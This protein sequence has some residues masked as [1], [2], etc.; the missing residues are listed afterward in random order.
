MESRSRADTHMMSSLIILLTA[1]VLN[2]F[3]SSK[4]QSQIPESIEINGR[5]GF[6]MT[7]DKG[8]TD[9]E[10]SLSSPSSITSASSCSLQIIAEDQFYN[11]YP[12]SFTL[13]K[14]EQGFVVPYFTIKSL[15]IDEDSRYHG[16]HISTIVLKIG[17]KKVFTE[18]WAKT[19]HQFQYTLI[20]PNL[21]TGQLIYHDITMGQ[22]LTIELVRSENPINVEI[23]IEPL[24]AKVSGLARK[25]MK[26][27]DDG[28]THQLDSSQSEYNPNSQTSSR[29]LSFDV[30]NAF[31]L[32]ILLYKK[33]KYGEAI[34]SLNKVKPITPFDSAFINRFKAN[35]YVFLDDNENA[36][37]HLSQA[38]NI[39]ILSE[40]DHA[41]SLK[42]LADLYLSVNKFQEAIK[43][44]EKW[45]EYTGKSEYEIQGN[46]NMAREGLN[47]IV[48]E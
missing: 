13:E 28:A 47:T 21:E 24:S 41:N 26:L 39:E 48:N 44:Y 29:E 6:I 7:D 8:D 15:Y 14:S 25:C 45:M 18:Q 38:T 31:Q 30:K 11:S 22:P 33:E 32:G 37:K 40:K 27:L 2:L 34:E 10:A 5:F 4:V 17:S 12:A 9:I 19:L 20:A 43:N 35:I 3:L 46:L 42:L 36:I 23:N 1:V 16:N